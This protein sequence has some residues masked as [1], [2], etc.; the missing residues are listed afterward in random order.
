MRVNKK[1]RGFTYLEIIISLAIMSIIV[2][3]LLN[4]SRSALTSGREVSKRFEIQ[5]DVTYTSNT[6][7]ETIRD[8]TAIFFVNEDKFASNLATDAVINDPTN[9]SSLKMTS[10]WNYIALNKEKDKIYNFIWDPDTSKHIPILLTLSNKDQITKSGVTLPTV[11]YDIKFDSQQ[12][13][14]QKELDKYKSFSNLTDVQK[15]EMAELE[16]KLRNSRSSVIYSIEGKVENSGL[17]VGDNDKF[18]SYKVDS[19]VYAQNTRQVNDIS[20][21]REITA[22][23]YRNTN[24]LTAEKVTEVPAVVMVLDY[25]GS[26]RGHLDGKVK[27]DTLLSE[28]QKVLKSLMALGDFDLYVVPFGTSAFS[29]DALQTFDHKPFTSRKDFLDNKMPIK[30]K[31]N[32][33]FDDTIDIMDE[34]DARYSNYLG[35]KFLNRYCSPHGWTNYADG[36]RVGLDYV[37]K[38]PRSKTYLFVLSDGAPNYINVDKNWNEYIGDN[39][40][41]YKQVGGTEA[42]QFIGRIIQNSTRKPDLVYVVGFA[43]PGSSE[44]QHLE[45]ITK[46]FVDRLQV[47]ITSVDEQENIKKNK[48]KKIEAG[49]PV[50]LNEAFKS[51]VDDIGKDLWYFDGP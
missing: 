43:K 16:T 51:F 28:Y 42:T 3:L 25:S 32:N 40:Y 38:S 24:V 37:K 13:Q 33:Q 31:R 4:V 9:I 30:V 48:V 27:I 15:Q 8:A 21:G 14:L 6:F 12:I 41:Y 44:N 10:G 1:K 18:G 35:Y 22:I 39:P 19:I 11:K 36:V 17:G 29:N 26:M 47:G 50:A 20:Q 34:N 23:A 45:N 7:N 5:S 2:L 49:S 46:H